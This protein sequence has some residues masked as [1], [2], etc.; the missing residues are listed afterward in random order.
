MKKFLI[1]INLNGQYCCVIKSYTRT[2]CVRT[3]KPLFLYLTG[4]KQRSLASDNAITEIRASLIAVSSAMGGQS[5]PAQSLA[6][7]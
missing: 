6:A 7:F 3:L 2:V 5:T 4:F 1:I